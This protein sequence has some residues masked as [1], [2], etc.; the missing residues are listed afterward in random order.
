MPTFLPPLFSRRPALQPAAPTLRPAATAPIAAPG[1]SFR[2]F[3]PI[4]FSQRGGA[5]AESAP[6]AQP[7]GPRAAHV[8]RVAL[9]VAVAGALIACDLWGLQLWNRDVARV[10]QVAQVAQGD[11]KGQAES[12]VMLQAV[13]EAMEIGGDRGGG[14][15][16]GTSHS[17]PGDSSKRGSSSSSS[18]SSSSAVVYR[19]APWKADVGTWLVECSEQFLDVTVGEALFA[20]ACP[21]NCSG[22][23]VCNH[24]LGECRCRHGYSGPDCSQL[25]LHQCNLPASP[26]WPVGPWVAS[27]CP[28]H[29]DTA[30]ALCFCGNGTRFPHRSITHPCGFV[31]RNH[32]F[33]FSEVDTDLLFH[34]HTGYCNADPLVGFQRDYTGCGIC[35]VDGYLGP[36]CDTRVES[37][38]L[39]Q[40]SLHGVCHRGY[41]ECSDGFFGI[42]CSVPSTFTPHVLST[43]PHDLPRRRL[44]DHAGGALEAQERGGGAV[45]G[46]VAAAGGTAVQQKVGAAAVAKSQVK[47]FDSSRREQQ[48]QQR[49]QQQQ[50]GE[51]VPT[52]HWA[53]WAQRR[54]FRSTQKEQR[55]G[56]HVGGRRW[57][58]RRPPLIYIY[59]LP[60]EFTF[61]HLEARKIRAYCTTRLYGMRNETLYN[62]FQLY[63][64]EVAV[65]ES[66][67]A[68]PHRT[69]NAS[70]ADYFF[71]P[72]MGGCITARA[73]D[74]PGT[75]MQGRFKNRRSYFAADYYQRALEHIRSAYPYWDRTGGRDH[76]WTFPWDEGACSAPQ[77]VFNGIMLSHW[78]NT[79][80]AHDHS[81]T[82]YLLDSWHD[83]PTALRGR[84]ACFDPLKDVVMPAFK[85]PSAEHLRERLWLN[86]VENRR[87]LFFFGGN[88]GLNFTHGRPEANYS[89]GI[90]QRVALYFASEPN[91][92]GQVGLLAQ[93]DVVVQPGP[94]YDYAVQ[95]SQSRF[96]GVLPGD[97][98]SARMEDSLLHG[99]IPVIVQDGIELPFENFLDYPSFTVRVAEA[100]IPNLVTILQS[101]TDDQVR[102]MQRAASR[103]WMRW[104]YRAAVL[105]EAGRQRA[106]GKEVG[107]WVADLEGME[108]DDAVDT[109]MQILHMKMFRDAWRRQEGPIMCSREGKVPSNIVAMSK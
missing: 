50:Q 27:I 11:R 94:I 10:A 41:C 102:A 67:L 76:I 84:H 66:L 85:P 25:H 57:V 97:G 64:M 47:D 51:A 12:Q 29:C 71:V 59:D 105:L 15:G 14:S 28:A 2:A 39:N 5:I 36:F 4:T 45:A 82:A 42:D 52:G 96:C 44:R 54:A 79:M 104:F 80:A 100:H 43:M 3:Q 78:G 93:P 92:H 81:T 7:R 17:S 63:G 75:S 62:H 86:P 99:C 6:G 73:D 108:G 49:Q 13:E 16:E 1:T 56:K 68:S 53:R 8:A 48:Q 106:Q 38:C 55:Q 46:V 69:T 101:F 30:T 20:H 107:E 9:L 40:C 37:F 26:E 21:G 74:S 22:N 34:A 83:I 91:R 33:V 72:V 95:L 23:G 31:Y 24:E 90:R 18:S 60:A 98:F 32:D 88:L 87:R 77:E 103:V 19:G 70:A 109:L 65:L 89:M 61:N 58:R 35:E